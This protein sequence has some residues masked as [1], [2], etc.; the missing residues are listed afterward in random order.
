MDFLEG[1]STIDFGI[2]SV[3]GI[4]KLLFLV[5]IFGYLVY[6]F[7][8][9]MRV[10]ILADTIKTPSNLTAKLISYIHLFVAVVGSLLAVILIL[11][12]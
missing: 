2:G 10:R 7:L 6:V 4:I 5:V 3:T 9:T 11:V 8:L 1:I 12:G